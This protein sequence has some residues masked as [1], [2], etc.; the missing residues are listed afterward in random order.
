MVKHT[1][2]R[3]T[4]VSEAAHCVTCTAGSE[5]PDLNRSSVLD[6]AA[7]AQIREMLFLVSLKIILF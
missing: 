2:E 3:L 7:D 4:A 6:W 1:I 5:S